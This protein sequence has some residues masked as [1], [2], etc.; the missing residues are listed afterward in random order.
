MYIYIYICICIRVQAFKGLWGIRECRTVNPQARNPQTKSRR[1][2]FLEAPC[3]PWE[4]H[5]L[6]LRI[7]SRQTLRIRDCQ[8]V[9]WPCM[10]QDPCQ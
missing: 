2:D 6:E 3:G 7:C 10:C 1:L 9:D 5:P 8:S 4:F